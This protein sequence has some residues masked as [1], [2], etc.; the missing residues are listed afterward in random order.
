MTMTISVMDSAAAQRPVAALAELQ[1]DEIAEHHVLAAAQ[2]ARRHIGAERWNEHQDGA[3]DDAG[4]HQRNDD[5]PQH[6]EPR[7]IEVIAR[8]HQAEIEFFHAGVK[9]QH[10]QRQIDIDHAQHDG[11]SR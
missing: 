1:L 7:G 8:F 11:R 5:A 6:L 3:R 2:H 4:L 9:R 10:H